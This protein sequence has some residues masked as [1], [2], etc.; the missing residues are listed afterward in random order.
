MGCPRKVRFPPDSDQTA[1]IAGGPVRAN[2][3][4]AIIPNST[5]GVFETARQAN[6]DDGLLFRRMSRF[7][8]LAICVLEQNETTGWYV[9]LVSV[10]R[11]VFGRSIKPNREHALRHRMPI[12]LS[13]ARRNSRET[14]VCR[15][16]TR[17]HIERRGIGMD[18]PGDCWN[19]NFIEV[20]FAVLGGLN[21][22]ALHRRLHS[23]N[24]TMPHFYHRTRRDQ[25][26]FGVKSGS[27][28][29]SAPGRLHP[30]KRTSLKTA[31]MSTLWGNLGNAGRPVIAGRHRSLP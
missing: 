3:G 13:G 25:V 30:R 22:Q 16:I 12:N 1:D 7:V 29:P 11:L 5:S 31:A 18:L 21:A 6:P 14:D 24:C 2:S 15:R 17:R 8:S 27:V 28:G 4:H 20:G 26:C 19:F 23:A 9:P 10:T